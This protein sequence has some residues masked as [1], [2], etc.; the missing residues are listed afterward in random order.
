MKH[1]LKLSVLIVSLAA[2][3][4]FASGVS[5]FESRTGD[6]ITVPS[7]ETVDGTL[8]A[9]GRNVKIEGAVAGD[10]ICAG[11]EIEIAGP[12]S[13]DVIC[14]AQNIRISGAVSGN[15]RA[16]AQNI[17][18]T[19]P[20]LRN[21]TAFTQR[22]ETGNVIEGEVFFATQDAVLS[23]EIKQNVKGFGNTVTVDGKIGRNAEFTVSKLVLGNNAEIN[24]NLAYT[25]GAEAERAYGAVV[26]GQVTR[27][28]PPQAEQAAQRPERN[29]LATLARSLAIYLVTALLLAAFF[30]KA[31]V[32][33]T[34]A[35]LANPAKTLGIGALILVGVPII[36]AALVLTILG[37]PLALIIILFF[38]AA[39]FLSRVFTAVAV[40]R[41][42][43]RLYWRNKQ[44]SVYAAAIIGV[45]VSW[46]AFSI[47]VAGGILSIVSI[48]WGLGGIYH[49]FRTR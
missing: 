21:V 44:E 3:C 45:I 37:I 36:S 8:F 5:A 31:V 38:A 11:Q 26:L 18:I 32:R 15:I 30:E 39:I 9:S 13:G 20:V 46:L 49:L 7:A 16:A 14:A 33:A 1:T 29:W 47:P 2:G 40:G 24:G 25:S 48:I 35:M 28:E 12:V 4:L 41:K 23:G 22:F 43:T 6:N 17:R 10:V 34:N 27:H 42:L 19:G